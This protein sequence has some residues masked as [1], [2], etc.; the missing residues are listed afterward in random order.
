MESNAPSDN[1]PELPQKVAYAE[2]VKHVTH[3][4]HA[5][6]NI[7]HILLDLP[8]DILRIF[9]AEGITIY[10]ADLDKK[11][12]YSK[13]LRLGTVEEIRVPINEQSLAGFTAK[14]LTPV[15]IT[16]AYDQAELTAIHPSLTFNRSW[17]KK[18]ALTRIR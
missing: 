17:D 13:A 7:D 16:D 14:F 4:I 11:E 5:A 1:L 3:Q 6:Q 2:Q 12:L 15:T 9:D 8:K 18:S 10:A